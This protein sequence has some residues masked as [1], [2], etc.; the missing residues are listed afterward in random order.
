MARAS[1]RRFRPWLPS[2]DLPLLLC[3]LWA[4]VVTIRDIAVP[5][6]EYTPLHS[7]SLNG[8]TRVA[9]LLLD[10]G[11]PVDV[12]EKVRPP[13][14]VLVKADEAGRARGW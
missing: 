6:E 5:Q 8:H 9:E 10:E 13:L 14:L 2:A 1:V 11:V 12:E 4:A 7:A 3:A